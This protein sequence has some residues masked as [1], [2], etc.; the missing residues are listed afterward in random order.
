M[1]IAL[2]REG[3][4]MTILSEMFDIAVLMERRVMGLLMDG[5]TWLN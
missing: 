1:N 3:D 4:D 5:W 2:L